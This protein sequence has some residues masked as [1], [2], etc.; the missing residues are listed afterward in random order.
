MKVIKISL[1]M[2]LFPALAACGGSPEPARSAEASPIHARVETVSAAAVDLAYEAV[3][4]VRSRTTA[5]LSAK[6]V[7]H[8]TAV[9]VREGDAVRAGQLLVEIDDRD[10]ANQKLKVT[11]AVAEAENALQ[12]VE[13]SIRAAEAGKSAVEANQALATATYQRFSRLHERGS[14]SRQEFDEVEAR[15]KSAVAEASRAEDMLQSAMARKRQVQ[16]RIEQARADLQNTDV[17]A[18][19]ARVVS[20]MNG[21][22]TAKSVDVGTL[23][24]PGVPLLTVEDNRSYQLVVSV[25]ESRI[26]TVKPGA[27]VTVSIGALG[28]A[29]V[30]ARVAEIVPAADPGSRSFTVKLELTP[31]PLLRSGMFGKARFAM[32][33]KSA[34]TVPSSAVVERGQLTG[35]FVVDSSNAARYRLIRTGRSYGDRIEVIS[36]LNP[37]DR[38]VLEEPGKVREGVLIE[39][40]TPANQR[41]VID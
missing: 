4:T 3:G 29:D 12:E 13:Q 14:A 31:H 36:G 8:V 5:H 40:K 2:A 9:R 11:A 22:V 6:T 19:Y 16:A 39:T 15:Y 10:V 28:E 41:A 33:E 20:P 37:G 26:G 21:V 7:G 35:V 32:G 27:A 18:S 38:L 24:A 30:P 34:L 25:D 23:A 1:M 17:Y